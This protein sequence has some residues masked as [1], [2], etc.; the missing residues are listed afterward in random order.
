[1]DRPNIAKIAWIIARV[2]LDRLCGWC[3][4]CVFLCFVLAFGP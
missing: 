2:W 1:M 3:C 4:F